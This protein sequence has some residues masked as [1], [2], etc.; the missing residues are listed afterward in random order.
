MRQKKNSKQISLTSPSNLVDQPKEPWWKTA[1]VYQIYPRSFQDSN[2]DGIGDLQGIINKLDYL[3]GKPNS[4]GIDAIWLSPIYPSP[5]VDFGYD[6]SD[7]EGIDPIFG[8]IYTFKLLLKEAH[9]RKIKII[10]DLVINHT[11]NLHPWFLESKS[12]KDNPKRNWYIWED[13]ING[14]PP[15]NWLSAFGGSGWEYDPQ[16]EQYYFHGFT[17]EQPDLNWRN[18]D[19]KKAIFKMIKYWLDI[20]VDGFRLDVVNYYFKDSQLRNNPSS[21]FR[22]FRPYERQYHFF[23]R[24]LP[25][26]HI[27]LQEFREL[28]DSYEGDRMSVGEVFVPP[29]G[30]VKIPAMYYGQEKKELHMAFNFAFLYTK[31]NAKLFQERIEEW[32]TALKQ[33]NWPNY[34]LSNHDNKRHISRYS[35][36][37]HTLH[38]AKIAA[39]MLLTLRGTPFLYYGEEIGMLSDYIPKNRIQDPV[40]ITY[41]PLPVGRDHARQPMCWNTEKFSGFS[42][43]EPWL[44]IS[45]HFQKNNVYSQELDQNSLLNIYK[46]LIKLRKKEVCLQLGSIKVIFRSQEKILSYIRIFENTKILIILNFSSEETRF[47]SGSEGLDYERGKILFS[48]HKKEDSFFDLNIISLLPYEAN[49]LKLE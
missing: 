3:N 34:T 33:S 5:M 19:V 47:Y 32:E 11:S 30:D 40:G 44:P 2:N 9:E 41:Y 49:I 28:L 23:D 16:T 38:R 17:K 36:G 1:I 8:D 46:K 31:W 48:T 37:N 10:M 12:S 14:K 20:G 35:K 13:P 43:V 15:N 4:L 7:Y 27:V 22:G 6:I 29:P 39:T 18:P 25:E 45:K 21:F 24:D 26:T 42:E